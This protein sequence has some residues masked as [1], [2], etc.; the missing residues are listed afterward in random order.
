MVTF[1]L[2]DGLHVRKNPWRN[3]GFGKG[4]FY[5]AHNPSGGASSAQIEQRERLAQAA[6]ESYSECN[7]LS[8]MSKN[9]C[10][11]RQISQAL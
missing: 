6:Q 11:A 4:E 5:L 2:T 9:A 1:S 10:R 3:T 7:G 8:G